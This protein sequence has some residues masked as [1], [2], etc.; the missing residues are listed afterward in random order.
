MKGCH[1]R[2]ILRHVRGV[3][4]ILP[5]WFPESCRDRQKDFFQQEKQRASYRGK[6][7]MVLR[8]AVLGV[9]DLGK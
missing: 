2:V 1:D 5:G 8:L 7:F 6:D 3:S 9:F 4:E